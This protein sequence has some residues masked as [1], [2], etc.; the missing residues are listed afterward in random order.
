MKVLM[1][2]FRRTIRHPKGCIKRLRKEL[3][4]AKPILD[5]SQYIEGGNRVHYG[6]VQFLAD[7]RL[8]RKYL[9]N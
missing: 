7:K 4:S 2:D 9:N 3:Y 6:Q 5:R 1:G 8:C